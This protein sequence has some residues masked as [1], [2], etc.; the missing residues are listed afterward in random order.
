M[1]RVEWTRTSPDDVEAVVGMLLCSQSPNAVRIR[2]S[3]GD[4]GI[5]IFI[6]GDAGWG[7]ER[8]VWQVKRYCANL[9][10]V[11]SR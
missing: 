5:D 3:Q 1:A 2:P 11:L 9:T 7:K 4:G 8:V 10:S 6:P